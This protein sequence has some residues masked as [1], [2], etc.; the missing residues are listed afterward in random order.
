M[1]RKP[2]DCVDFKIYLRRELA[3]R[4]AAQCERCDF[5]RS[6]LAQLLIESWTEEMETAEKEML[7]CGK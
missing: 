7:E 3:E 1:T 5:K 6:P 4:F 2:R